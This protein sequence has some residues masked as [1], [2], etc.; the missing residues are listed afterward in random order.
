MPL[1]IVGGMAVPVPALTGLFDKIIDELSARE[2]RDHEL[3]MQQLKL[4]ESSSLKDEYARQLLLDRLLYP[5]EAAQHDIQNCAK[6]A[7]WLAQAVTYHYQDHGLAEEQAHELAR[8]LRLI[9]IHITNIDSLHDL[10]Q[11]YG[12]VTLFINEISIFKHRDYKYSI[13]SS[14]RKGILEPLNTCIATERNFIRR[15]Q[16]ME[17]QI[18]LKPRS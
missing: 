9:A 12:A 18:A 3:K 10:K 7:Q 14:V 11:V 2:R 6:H 8:Q 5:V 17:E 15:M 4:I 1:N 16:F 13:E